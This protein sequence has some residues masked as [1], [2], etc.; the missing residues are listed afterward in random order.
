M[1]KNKINKKISSPYFKTLGILQ[2]PC[3]AFFYGM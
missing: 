3:H 2:K 1:Y